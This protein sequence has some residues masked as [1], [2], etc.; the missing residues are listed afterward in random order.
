M[1]LRLIPATT[2]VLCLALVATVQAQSYNTESGASYHSLTPVTRPVSLGGAATGVDLGDFRLHPGISLRGGFD[3]NVFFEEELEG[4]ESAAIVNVMPSLRL[5]TEDPRGI[6]LN[7]NFQ[8]LWEYYP[9][10]PEEVTSQN[11]IDILGD[12]SLQ[13][14]PRGVASVT[15]YDSIRRRADSPTAPGIETQNH[16]Y[17]EIGLAAAL[18]PG[19]SERTSRRGF[20]GGL[21]LGYG[22]E[23]WDDQLEL[24]RTMFLSSLVLKYFFLPKTAVRLNASFSSI[25]YDVANRSVVVEDDT[26]GLEAAFEDTLVNVDSSPFRVTLGVAGLLTRAIDFEVAGGYGMGNYSTGLDY[27]SWLAMGRVGVFFTPNAHLSA[28]YQRD[29]NDSSFGNYYEFDRFFG[30][31]RIDAGDWLVGGGGGYEIQRFAHLD[32]PI[33]NIGGQLFALY[34]SEDR[35]DPVVTADFF[36]SWNF[37]DWARITGSYEFRGNLTDFF[38]T[39]GRSSGPGR[40]NSSASQYLKHQVFFGTEFEY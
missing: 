22:I 20:A 12:V 39:T 40:P 24:D 13:I 14:G 5:A 30:D 6:N 8:L 38:V 16:L 23:L 9:S 36:V 19:G 26:I 21:T 35:T 2:L 4:T 34:S 15:L 32:S 28:G 3:S 1:R 37:T 17:N 10:G 7:T 31:L 29:F 25:S 33:L 27:K 11:G 18:H